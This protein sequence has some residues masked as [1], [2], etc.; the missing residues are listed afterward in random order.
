MSRRALRVGPFKDRRRP[1]KVPGG[2]FVGRFRVMVRGREPMLAFTRGRR[3]AVATSSL[4]ALAVSLAWT[5]GA[6]AQT[7]TKAAAAKADDATVV[8]EIVVGNPTF[9]R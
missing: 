1:G 5:G 3:A 4:L 7:T 2:S 9:I 6:G 8:E